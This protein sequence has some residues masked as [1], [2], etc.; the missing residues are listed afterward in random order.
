MPYVLILYYSRNGATR[1]LARAIA[2]GVEA[3]GI[4]AKLRTVKPVSD[5]PREAP[6]EEHDIYCTREELSQCSGLILGSPTR[7]G[8][9]AAALKYFIEGSSGDWLN[10]ALIG[11]PAAAFTS[12]GSMHGG[13]ESTLLSMMLP[14]LHHGMLITGIP[15]S[16]AAISST[17]TGGSPYGASHLAEN[18]KDAELSDDEITICEALGRRVAKLALTLGG[19]S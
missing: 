16:E 3:A 12:T 5:E 13:Q 19:D 10:G 9:M 17:R 2:R 14:L 4:E 8:H 15:Y 7:F 11:K 6:I 1:A 18:S